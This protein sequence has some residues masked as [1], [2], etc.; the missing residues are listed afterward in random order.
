MQLQSYT[1]SVCVCKYVYN[2]VYIVCATRRRELSAKRKYLCCKSLR[3]AV[4]I[5]VVFVLFLFIFFIF[6]FSALVSCSFAPRFV[7]CLSC[8]HILQRFFL[9]SSFWCLRLR[10]FCFCFCFDCSGS[11][12]CVYVILVNGI[13]WLGRRV[14]FS[15]ISFISLSFSLSLSRVKIFYNIYKHMSLSLSLHLSARVRV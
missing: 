9:L 3:L 5:V 4:D 8:L 7:T 11:L 1:L 15:F 10:L 12:C 14:N 6:L 13:S 2:H